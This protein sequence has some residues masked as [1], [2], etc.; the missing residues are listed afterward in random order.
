MGKYKIYPLHLGTI[1]RPKSQLVATDKSGLVIDIPIL[2]WYVTDGEHKILIDTGG[3]PPDGVHFMPYVR[4]EEQSLEASL[5]RLGVATDEIDTVIL[6]HLHWDHGGC[7]TIFPKAK[8]YVQRSE[9]HYAIDPLPTQKGNYDLRR[10][11]AVD[12]EIL[13]GDCE[14]LDGIS[15]VLSPG[16]SNGHQCVIVNTE[17]GPY[18]VLG[19]MVNLLEAWEADPPIA[20]GYH[21][22]LLDYHNS[23]KKLKKLKVSYVLAGHDPTVL[24][25]KVYPF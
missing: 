24:E 15:V 21:V 12:Y 5:N 10:V 19:D 2:A 16:H 9:L 11:F 6:T 18:L 13:D 1:T 25:H 7:M 4:P 3:T 8:F 23:F 14:V 20:N 17:A 22:S